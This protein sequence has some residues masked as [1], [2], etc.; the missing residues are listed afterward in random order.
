MSEANRQ[1]GKQPDAKS[2]TKVTEFTIDRS[3]WGRGCGDGILL[4]PDDGKMC[5]LG[6]Y[7][8]ACGVSPS[9]INNQGFPS[10]VA[11]LPGEMDWLFRAFSDESVTPAEEQIASTN[12]KENLLAKDRE[13]KIREHFAT[14]G[15]KVKFTGR[16]K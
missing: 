12:D 3:K 7:A 10:D 2:Q 16:T 14:R 5:C 6:F 9:S 11:A 13:K 1:C 4:S 15:I 8:L